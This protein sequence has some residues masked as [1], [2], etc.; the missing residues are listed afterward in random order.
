M[1]CMDK[2]Y[3][4]EGKIIDGINVFMTEDE[5]EE[6]N[7]KFSK[8]YNK[9]ASFYD[10]SGKLF[11]LLKFGGEFNFRNESLKYIKGT[12]KNRNFSLIFSFI[13]YKFIIE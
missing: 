8:T 9:I 6:N 3:K 11:F 10:L 4:V 2:I 1:E 13:K 7:R 5:L 12:S